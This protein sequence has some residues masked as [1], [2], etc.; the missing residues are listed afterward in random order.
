M[1]SIICQNFGGL[2]CSED[3]FRVAE[4]ELKY[5]FRCS[6]FNILCHSPTILFASL[7]FSNFSGDKSDTPNSA[8][9]KHLFVPSEKNLSQKEVEIVTFT[10]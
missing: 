4:I 6:I 5:V 2:E 9:I 1:I 7:A 3:P 10:T 8:L